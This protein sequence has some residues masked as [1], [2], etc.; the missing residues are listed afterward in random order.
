MQPG[1]VIAHGRD[2]P[3]RHRL[4]RDQHREVGLAAGRRERRRDI[5]RFALRAREADDEHVLGEPAFVARLVARD[6]QRMTLFAEQGV[7]AVAAAEAHDRELFGEVHD[8][9]AV[10]VELARGV[11]ALHEAALARDALE[12]RATRAG[13]QDHVDDD[14]GA[15][16][17]LDAAARVGR[18]DRAHA[19]RDHVERATL[20]A[21]LEEAQHLGLGVSR[22]HP[23]VVRAG[24]FPVGGAHEGEVLD[25]RHI[26][27]MGAG[28]E[29]VGVMRLVELLQF[30]AR[31]EFG[32]Q[33]AILVVRPF[34][35][36]HPF[37]LRELPY[38][39]DPFA[40]GGGHRGQGGQGEG[41]GGHRR[42][43]Q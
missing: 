35:P 25:T 4:G 23:V 41:C 37:G 8:E 5:V 22:R 36:V 19:I 31:F 21:A 16:G 14:I 38:R 39:G 20:H 7:A 11:Q 15:V 27:G 28:E 34:T 32:D 33:S 30:A 9:A 2:L 42:S 6:A 29:A 13:H 1:D 12:R 43:F 26:G 10:R 18:V 17:D 3:A 24:V 40:H